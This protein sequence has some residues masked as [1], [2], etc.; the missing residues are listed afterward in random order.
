[1]KLIIDMVHHNPGESQTFSK[2]SDSSQL[3]RFGYNGQVWMDH[4]QTAITYRYFDKE[5]TKNEPELQNAIDARAANIYRKIEENNKAGI[6]SFFHTD[7]LVVPKKLKEKY[8]AEIC[9]EEGRIDLHLPKTQ[10]LI[11]AQVKE[12]FLRFPGLDGLIVRHGET[13]THDI[14]LFVGNGPISRGIES[15]ILLINLLREEICQRLNRYFIY[16]TWD[17]QGIHTNR[18]KYLKVTDSVEV[19]PKLVFSIKHTNADYWRS[20]PFNET[21]MQGKHRQIVEIQCQREYEGKG[22]HPNYIAH[23]VIEGFEELDTIMPEDSVKCLNDMRDNPLF[24]GIFTWSRGGGWNGPYIFNEFWVELNARVLA[25]WIINQSVSEEVHLHS[26]LAEMGIEK[27]DANL[28]REISL[29]SAKAV[30]RGQYSIDV[31]PKLYNN[32]IKFSTS[33]RAYCIEDGIEIIWTRD[34]FIGG[35]NEVK[36]SLKTLTEMQLYT[37]FLKEKRRGVLLWEKIVEKALQLNLN[38]NPELKELI[39]VTCNYGLIKFIIL[40]LAWEFFIFDHSMK[41]KIETEID[42]KLLS[43]K[44]QAAKQALSQ[45]KKDS[46]ICPGIYSMDYCEYIPQKGMKKAPGLDEFVKSLVAKEFRIPFVE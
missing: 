16:R 26:V 20:V 7:F 11:V 30:V 34:H 31:A 39:N 15:H 42:P 22:A 2:F 29:L 3:K 24:A 41:N 10:E 35:P 18:S 4:I 6:Q 5:L 38:Y 44:Y 46:A 37:P 19:H 12:I 17:F 1:M 21:L 36:A 8:K 43:E 40:E 45:L 32:Q 27:G 23:G 25:K 13:Y 14:P 9:N 28:I 33:S